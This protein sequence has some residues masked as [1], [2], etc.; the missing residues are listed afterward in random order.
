MSNLH[1]IGAIYDPEEA[2][3]AQSFLIAHGFHAQLANH[4]MLTA[5]PMYRIALGGHRLIVPAAEREEAFEFLKVARE[6]PNKAGPACLSCGHEDY[7]RIKGLLFPALFF[8]F[9][10]GAIVPFGW[11]TGYLECRSCKTRV[12]SDCTTKMES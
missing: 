10:M 11:N 12:K 6:A 9:F 1:E 3:V 7:R 5:N 4:R 2:Y 8:L